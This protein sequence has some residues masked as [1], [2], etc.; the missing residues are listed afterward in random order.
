MDTRTLT[1]EG[2]REA[3]EAKIHALCRALNEAGAHPRWAR[4]QLH[5][6]INETFEVTDGMDSM[7]FESFPRLERLLMAKLVAQK[8]AVPA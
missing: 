4:S 7:T 2:E 8:E 3:W 1:A 6:F 5:L